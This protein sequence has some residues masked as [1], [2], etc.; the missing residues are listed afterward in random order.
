MATT[1][2][3]A[4][5]AGASYYDT[6]ADINRFSLPQN[7]SVVSRLPQDESTG[8]EASTFKNGTNIV[9]SFAETDPS[10]IPGDIAADLALAAGIL[11]DQLKQAADYY[12]L[13][14]AANSDAT[15][16][17]TGHSLGDMN[18]E[19]FLERIVCHEA[20]ERGQI[21]GLLPRLRD[22]YV[23][24]GATDMD[25]TDTHDLGAFADGRFPKASNN[26]DMEMAA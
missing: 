10:D 20:T 22:W 3:Y 9:I 7:W 4:L 8:F 6:R 26:Q 11:S 12:L 23:Q 1:I 16:C 19:N 17:F 24:A 15:I 18:D 2:E 25:A 21:E 13:I 14:K 5:L